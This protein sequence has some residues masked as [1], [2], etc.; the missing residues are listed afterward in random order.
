MLLMFQVED[1]ITRIALKG[2]EERYHVLSWALRTYPG[3]EMMADPAVGTKR[4]VTQCTMISKIKAFTRALICLLL[5][6]QLPPLLDRPT[7]TKLQ[8]QYLRALSDDYQGTVS[9][10]V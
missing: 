3:P 2:W 7:V 10:D 8:S 6:S 9:K 4:S 1:I 5:S